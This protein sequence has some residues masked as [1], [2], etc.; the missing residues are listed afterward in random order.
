MSRKTFM[1]YNKYDRII[2]CE[3][4]KRIRD[5]INSTYIMN[6]Q[7]NVDI[8]STIKIGKIRVS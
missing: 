6:K 5:R 4:M 1:K 2:L 3:Y 8:Y 7:K